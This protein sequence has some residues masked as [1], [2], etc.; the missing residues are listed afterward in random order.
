M[1]TMTAYSEGCPFIMRLREIESVVEQPYIQPHEI[2]NLET[3][4]LVFVQFTEN[5]L[6]TSEDAS[7]LFVLTFRRVY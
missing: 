5:K 2:G 4:R 3:P 6:L 7:S 1:R